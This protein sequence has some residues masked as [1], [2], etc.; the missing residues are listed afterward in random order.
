MR[1]GTFVI[2]RIGVFA[3]LSGV[4]SIAAGAAAQTP[5]P[6]PAK[7]PPAKQGLPRVEAG[8]KAWTGDL[9]AMIKRR[10][11][12]VLVPY[13]KTY[14]FV[15]RAVQRGLSYEVTR[16]LEADLNKKYRGRE[17]R[18]GDRDLRLQ[19]L[20]VLSRVPDDRGGARRAREDQRSAQKRHREVAR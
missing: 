4:L 15:D 5:A 12:R 3:I 11:I 9:D 19:H 8:V 14:Y 16:F 6:P 2:R 1:L 10:V 17:D 13:S 20:Q 18:P 7:Q